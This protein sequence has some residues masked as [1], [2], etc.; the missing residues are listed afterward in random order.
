MILELR[1]DRDKLVGSPEKLGIEEAVL[2]P[3]EEKIYSVLSSKA[4]HIDE[5]VEDI[6]VSASQISSI[7][8][9]LEIKN[10]VKELPGK[11]FVKKRRA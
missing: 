9:K 5:I 2:K 8:M 1:V 6:H 10:L 7:L 11:I 4:R 3:Q